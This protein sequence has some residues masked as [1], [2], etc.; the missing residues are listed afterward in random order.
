MRTWISIAL[1]SLSSAAAISGTPLPD[2]PHVVV[3]GEGK[4]SVEPDSAIVTM[5]AMHRAADAAEAKRV[6]DRAVNALLD[7]APRFDVE[8]DALSASDLSLQEDV[9]YD[10]DGR[11]RQP[12]MHIATREVEVRLDDLERLGAWTDAALAAGFTRIADIRFE[13]TR[14]ARLREDARARAVADAREKASGLASAF[15]GRLGPV[16][17]VNSPGMV[18][19]YGYGNTSLDSIVVTGPRVDEGRYLQP[20]IDV[21][22]RV[23][24]VFEIVR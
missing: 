14:Q 6:V 8:P 11:R 3:Q 5:V 1:L 19:A 16:Y 4:V 21:T 2:A 17:S 9:D 12:V 20:K 7:I 13:S 24:A 10:D 15:G 23:T 22:E 18:E